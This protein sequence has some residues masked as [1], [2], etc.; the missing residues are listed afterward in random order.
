MAMVLAS[1]VGKKRPFWRGFAL[2]A[3]TVGVYSLYW[4]YK[5][6][7][8]VFRQFELEREGRDEGVAW[9]ILGLVFLPLQ[10]V[11]FWILAANVA[12][13]RHRLALAPGI[14]PGVFVALVGAGLGAYFVGAFVLFST[15]GVLPSDAPTQETG[16]PRGPGLAAFVAGTAVAFLALPIAYGR[17]QRDI[18][19]VWDAYAARMREIPDGSGRPFT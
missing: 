3:A 6:H 1:A 11:Y 18:N 15:S 14:R 13:V 9:Y 7:S 12:Y 4:N 2:T 8:E 10:F 5:A 19:G 17:L 16:I